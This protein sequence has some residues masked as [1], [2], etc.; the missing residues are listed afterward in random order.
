MKK[1]ILVFI[2]LVL[3][4]FVAGCSDNLDTD[5]K[6]LYNDCGDNKHDSSWKVD[7]N[8]CN[9]Y[10]GKVFC[11]KTECV[12][13]ESNSSFSLGEILNDIEFNQ[14][15]TQ[16]EKEWLGYLE[17][18]YPQSKIYHIKTK[19]F[20]CNECYELSYKRDR[21]II[22]IKVLNGEKNS[23][24]TIV[25][26]I[27][28]DIENKD[29]CRLFQGEWNEC[30][31]LCNTD[32]DACSTQCGAPICE[33]DYNKIVFKKIGEECGG[34]DKGDC[35]YGLSCVYKSRD[36]DYGKCADK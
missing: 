16:Y 20:N 32:E 30:P 26:D 19:L 13:N 9:C 5:N 3:F 36:D 17:I 11:T 15:L 34:L 23:E 7:C 24:K 2:G 33:F 10:D 27:V 35:E 4:L 29:V 6:N 12:T 1:D 31:K 18:K 22:R 14:N 8:T 21:E 25:D 28:V